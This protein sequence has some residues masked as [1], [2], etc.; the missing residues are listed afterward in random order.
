[1]I[2]TLPPYLMLDGFA[3]HH[4]WDGVKAYLDLAKRGLRIELQLASKVLP[5][6]K[7]QVKQLALTPLSMDIIIDDGDHYPPVME[8]TLHRWWPYLRPG[9]YYCIED[10]ATGAN[11]KGQR[12]GGR[13][14]AFFFPDGSAPLVHNETYVSE[15]TTRAPLGDERSPARACACSADRL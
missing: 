13:K 11:S 7:E 3:E 14:G 4:G 9:G 1:M 10:V 12:Y 5:R 2:V 8:K 6:P 15:E